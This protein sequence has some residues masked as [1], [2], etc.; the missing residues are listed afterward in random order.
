LFFKNLIM[1]K[2]IEAFTDNIF[3]A[4]EISKKVELQKPKNEILNILICGMGGSGIGGKLVSQW[5]QNEIKIPVSLC[6]D[7]SIPAFVNKNTLV[8]CSSYSGNTEETLAAFH[9]AKAKNAHIVC[10][11]SGGEIQKLCIENNFDVI[12]V[13]G[14]NQ[15]RAAIGYSL[16]QLLFI[17]TQLNLISDKSLKDI[18]TGSNTIIKNLQRNKE[19]GK[20]IAE[21][22]FG[23]V[24]VIYTESA[25]ESMGVRAR[26]QLNENSKYLAWSLAIPEMNHNEL[27]GWGGGS[28]NFA[29][30]FFKT[31]DMNPRNAKRM[32]LTKEILAKKTKSI[33]ELE[34]NGS[35]I[36]ER[37]LH[38]NSVMDWASYY[39]VELNKVDAYDIIVI[40]YL[41][42]SLAKV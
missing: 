8:I 17:M 33:Y 6:Q 23:K 29:A 22:L 12:I 36:I 15:P 11:T 32:E 20:K 19:E 10:I 21:F 34:A 25:Y 28:D 30:I 24:G 9:A 3:E 16:V 27:V 7:Y 35:S 37:A 2:L 5:V 42:D 40:D 38:L 14:G 18:V 39:L 13:P 41:K 26:Q 31:N 4:I 1:E